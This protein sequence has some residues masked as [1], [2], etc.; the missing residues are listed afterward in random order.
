MNRQL[1]R[2]PIK[3]VKRVLS[4]GSRWLYRRLGVQFLDKPQTA[5]Y[6]APYQRSMYPANRLSLTEVIDL[7]DPSKVYFAATQDESEPVSVWL[8]EQA[9]GAFSQLPYGSIRDKQH[10]LCTDINT[11]DFYRNVLHR[12]KRQQ[13]SSTALIAPWSHYLDGVV[14]GGY[15]DFVMLVAGKLARIKDAIPETLFKEALVAYPLFKTAY[16]REY[17]SLLG[18]EPTRL[19]D[20]RTTQVRF[21]QCVL[22]NTGHWFYPNKADIDALRKHILPK[23]PPPTGKRN[24]IYISRAG[25]RRVRN[26]PD[27]INLL[28][29]YHIEV[30]EDK[31]RSV[32]E[33]IAIYQNAGFIIGPHGASFVNILWCQPGT[34]LFE[35]FAPTYF[36]DFYRNMAE[37]LGLRYSAYFHGPAETGGWAEGLEDDIY[38][39]VSEI[40]QCLEKLLN[41]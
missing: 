15:Y 19:L 36:P 6:L 29:Q 22:A 27:L 35:L 38:V 28:L 41:K 14:W 39:S 17:L 5:A 24:R 10:V 2:L 12:K 1:T 40:D 8:V 34:H 9:N 31:P 21:E 3:L 13:I 37:Q 26:E 30:I 7:A 32:A 23:L 18:I 20:S 4:R 11:D 25:R 33:Q 16:E